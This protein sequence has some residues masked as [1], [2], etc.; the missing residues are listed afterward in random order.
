M[1]KM[2]LFNKYSKLN[3]TLFKMPIKLIFLNTSFKENLKKTC[4]SLKPMKCYNKFNNDPLSPNNDLPVLNTIY[5]EVLKELY[6]GFD[7]NNSYFEYEFI[8]YDKNKKYDSNNPL[9]YKT[10]DLI[11]NFMY[12]IG[13]CIIDQIIFDRNY[14]GGRDWILIEFILDKNHKNSIDLYYK[15]SIKTRKNGLDKIKF[16]KLNL[17]N[18]W[19]TLECI[20]NSILR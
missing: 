15:I 7:I 9:V 1:F 2:N 11:D 12:E 3:Y 4:F 17:N 19:N 10:C 8:D 20:E 13:S 18:L 6:K 14:N 5:Y 16:D